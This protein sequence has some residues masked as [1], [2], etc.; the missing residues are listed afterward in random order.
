[1][2]ELAAMMAEAACSVERETVTASI[3]A[4]TQCLGEDNLSTTQR[5]DFTPKDPAANRYVW[6]PLSFFK[7]GWHAGGG[8]SLP[9]QKRRVVGVS[10][11][12]QC[13]LQCWVRCTKHF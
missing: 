10:A 13:L 12:K 9:A 8:F 6:L 1:M 3:I 11:W 5:Q 7:P 4:S 2:Q